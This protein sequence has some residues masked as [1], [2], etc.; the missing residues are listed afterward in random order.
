MIRTPPVVVKLKVVPSSNFALRGILIAPMKIPDVAPKPNTQRPYLSRISQALSP[1]RFVPT[2]SLPFSSFSVSR[3]FSCSSLMLSFWFWGLWLV[4][5][6]SVAI[7]LGSNSI[8]FSSSCLTSIFCF[9]FL[10]SLILL[11]PFFIWI[12]VLSVLSVPILDTT[13]VGWPVINAL[14]ISYLHPQF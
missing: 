9:W 5:I 13:H 14:S 12:S 10:S 2:C 8:L 11:S 1:L 7:L 4:S 3:S 6:F